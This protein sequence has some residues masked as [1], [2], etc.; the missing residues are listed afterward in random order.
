VSGLRP[1]FWDLPLQRLTPAEWEA[2]CDGCGRCCL[3]KLED[4]DTGEVAFT[5]VACRLLDGATC[6]CSQYAIRKSIVPDCVVLT[7]GTVKDVAYWLPQ[8]CAYRLRHYGQ[9]LFDWHPLISGDPDSVHR[10]GISVQGRIV[11]EYEIDVDDLEDYVID[12]DF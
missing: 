6:R 4:A 3:H 8:T 12:E 9:R 2:L 10:A 1:K 7:P 5:N 11:P